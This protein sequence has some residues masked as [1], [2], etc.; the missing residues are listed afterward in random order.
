MN[1]FS[2]S[3]DTFGIINTKAQQVSFAEL[4]IHLQKL[5][6]KTRFE[7]ATPS[8]ANAF[9]HTSGCLSAPTD[10]NRARHL[11]IRVYHVVSPRWYKNW[12]KNHW[13]TEG[14]ARWVRFT[15]TPVIRHRPKQQVMYLTGGACIRG[16]YL[17]NT[18][19]RQII[20]WTVAA[21]MF[22]SRR[23]LTACGNLPAETSLNLPVC[24]LMNGGP[25]NASN[26]GT[27][28]CRVLHQ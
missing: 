19:T 24:I 14:V 1:P 16:M 7:L 18:K 20:S 6:R 22:I 26:L 27:T 13:L 3:V 17:R 10:G 11:C 23:V 28:P 8:L 2:G 9:F 21:Y 5:E 4:L 25:L 12:Y 15:K